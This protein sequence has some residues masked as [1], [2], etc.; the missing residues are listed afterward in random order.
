[1][2]DTILVSGYSSAPKGT[3]MY[4]AYGQTGV[5]L[6]IDVGQKRIVGAEATFVTDLAKDFFRRLAV[7][8]D[9]GQGIEPLLKSISARLLTPS[10]DSLLV[11][12][13]A[14]FQRYLQA[15]ETR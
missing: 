5:I 2:A 15:V 3:T 13:R 7:G 6:E 9:L 14:A 1:M 10:A 4:Q 8:Y 12:C 11:A